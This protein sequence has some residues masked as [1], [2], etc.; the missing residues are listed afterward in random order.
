MGVAESS[1]LMIFTVILTMVLNYIFNVALGWFLPTEDY[2]VYGVSSS[3]IMLLSVFVSSGFPL[4]VA[5]FLS[6]EKDELIRLRIFK[7]VLAGNLL[8]ALIISTIFLIIYLSVLNFEEKYDPIV[9]LIVACVMVTAVSACYRGGLQG[10]FRF[11]SLASS[12]ILNTIVKLSGIGF[13][14]LGLGAFGAIFGVLLGVIVATIYMML[15]L[16]LKFWKAKGFDSRVFNFAIPVFVGLLS[17][18]F[19]QNIDLLSLKVLTGSD[20]LAGYYQA[21]ITIARIPFWIAGAVLTVVFPYISSTKKS[22][23][24]N[25]TLKYSIIFLL[26]PALFICLAPSSFIKL[27]YPERYLQASQ[28][29]SIASL[30]IIFLTLNYTFMNILQAVGKPEIPAKILFASLIFQAILL[31]ILIPKFGLI[32]APLSTLISMAVCFAL[33]LYKYAKFFGDSLNPSTLLTFT[34]IC[35]ITLAVFL[36]IPHHSRL[37]LTV[38]LFV[39]LALYIAL[40]IGLKILDR[41][42]I[43]ILFRPIPIA[44]RIV[45]KLID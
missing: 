11:K 12:N 33:L 35:T 7:S 9:Y 13:V 37:F 24:S 14:I 27:I 44:N 43:G 41:E 28:A 10:T 30:A 38:D 1:L 8:T 20:K 15:S 34:S 17:I 39:S 18:T 21:A 42:D 40:L 19:V 29:L 16:R 25:K 26:L 45:E 6:E 5:K 23:Y 4:T 22:V 36:L 2:G 31:Y 32:G 3:F